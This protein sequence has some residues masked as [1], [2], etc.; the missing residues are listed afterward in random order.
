MSTAQAGWIASAN[1][2][3]YLAGALWAGRSIA[4][5]QP[6]SIAALGVVL[7]VAT[8]A[9]MAID[10]GALGWAAVR[11]VSGLGSALAMV[12]MSSLVLRYLT[13][14]ERADLAALPY[15]G[16]GSAIAVSAVVSGLMQPQASF[17]SH[18]GAQ[19]ALALMFGGIG[20][21]WLKQV[22]NTSMSPAPLHRQEN[23][24]SDAA[25]GAA[26]AP[27]QRALRLLV[28][29]YTGLGFGY[30]ITATFL[31]VVVRAMGLGLW[32]ETLA[33]VATGVSAVLTNSAWHR[34]ALRIGV[35][36]VLMVQHA[37]LALGV[38]LPVI[39]QG[40]LPALAGAVLLGATFMSA[41]GLILKEG[42]QLVPAQP[43]Q[44]IGALT[45]GFGFGQ[46]LG[47][48]VVAIWTHTLHDGLVGP[49][50]LA[51]TVLLLGA[52]AIGKASR[53]AALAKSHQAPA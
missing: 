48:A 16:V 10:V 15:I 1:F 51:A 23:R 29:G 24:H 11:F 44:S 45:A 40:V 7:S 5:R 38:L 31:V 25:A 21:A 30:V 19:A 12:C 34:L 4:A 52:A 6:F 39:A 3:G 37:L 28:I 26:I 32:L 49:S 14:R 13:L 42:G 46:L 41:T 35:Y 17:A 18:W 36:R 2:I 22:P 53:L 9:L 8:T 43:Q 20:I 50:W 27:G 47:P 33:W